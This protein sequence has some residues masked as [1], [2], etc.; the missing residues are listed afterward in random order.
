MQ[1][2][3]MEK[4]E[5]LNNILFREEQNYRS[6]ESDLLSGTMFRKIVSR[7][8]NDESY[9]K[10][11]IFKLSFMCLK[12]F[13]GSLNII[14]GRTEYEKNV[15]ND[16]QETIETIAKIE[17]VHRTEIHVFF[18]AMDIL[19]FVGCNKPIIMSYF[20]KNKDFQYYDRKN[21]SDSLYYICIRIVECLIENG[22][23]EKAANI[24]EHLCWASN[25][26]NDKMRHITILLNIMPII[27][28]RLPETTYRICKCNEHYFEESDSDESANFYWFFAYATFGN[29][30]NAEGM[31]YLRKCL[32]IRK[33]LLGEE[34]WYTALTECEIVIRTMESY[35][36]ESVRKYFLEF[37]DK[38]ENCRFNDMD[39]NYAYLTEGKV[40][41]LLLSND[42]DMESIEQ[43]EY[44]VNLY[45][46]ICN[47]EMPVSSPLISIRVER[48]IRGAMHLRNGNY[49]EAEKCFLE[50]Y[51]MDSQTD[52]SFAILSDTMILSNLLTVYY[53]QGDIDK[54]C[55][56][57]DELLSLIGS[58]EDCGLSEDNC[59]GIYIILASVYSLI[60][61]DDDELQGLYEILEDV[62]DEI[63]LDEYR[64]S[65]YNKEQATFVIVASCVLS[66]KGYLLDEKTKKVYSV[67]R[68]IENNI[69]SVNWEKRRFAALYSVLGLLAYNL[70]LTEVELYL[71]KSLEYI[72]DFG[73]PFGVKTLILC[74][75]AM[76]YY[77]IDIERT[78]NYLYDAYETLTTTWQQSVR[79][80]NDTRLMNSLAIAQ[81]QYMILYSVQRRVF[82]VE[83]SYEILLK[84]KAIASLAGRER[85]YITQS[86]FID[87]EILKQINNQQ[88][89]LACLEADSVCH[90]NEEQLQEESRKLRQLEQ[91]FASFIPDANFFREI[92]YEQILKKIPENSSV[93][94]YFVAYDREKEGKFDLINS[95]VKQIIDIFVLTKINGICEIHKYEVQDADDT[96]MNAL[97]FIEIFQNYADGTATISQINEI[98]HIRYCIYDSIIKPIEKWIV[99]TE[100]LYIAPSETLVNVPFGLLQDDNGERLQEKYRI[101]KIEC[102]RDFLFENN[103][104]TT[105]EKNLIMG[106]PQYDTV[107]I[108]EKIRNE[109]TDNT[110]SIKLLHNDISPL[111]FSGIEVERIGQQM[112]SECY[113]G[114]EATKD[115]LL[116][117]TGYRCIHLAT[118]GWVDYDSTSDTLYSSCLFFAGAKNWLVNG[119]QIPG[120]GNGIVTADEISRLNWTSV[121]LVVLSSCMSGM[122]DYSIDKE[123]NGM[124]SALSAAGVKYV[125]SSL[126]SQDD[127]ATAIMMEEFYKRYQK[128]KQNPDEALRNAQN[129]LKN[130]SLGEIR[131]KGWFDTTDKR[132]GTILDQYQ[133]M[134]DRVKPFRDE[135]YWG[136]FECYQCN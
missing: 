69:G 81:M 123:F 24:V 65:E 102:A 118:H 25:S 128:E 47:K 51:E 64:L 59:Y 76:Y 17:N 70:G 80:L 84:F 26:R 89:Y 44:L 36:E 18:D 16:I 109:D 112:F 113:V 22:H 2:K 32:E 136:G 9:Q 131:S 127:L 83:E 63:L 3:S 31:E 122:N 95:N 19:S 39:M 43:Y 57:L 48:N 90:V 120:L 75:A 33:K 77:N 106:D 108:S 68:K 87:P 21:I 27:V 82:N 101:V 60:A 92:S 35:R 91:K 13:E 40:L 29:E 99:P 7:N 133:N 74:L 97:N 110:R 134:N 111:P 6:E 38:I 71:N 52:V 1:E 12:V 96:I 28:D 23:V 126:W 117:A 79:Y 116:L 5:L 53:V 15:K 58:D 8:T 135:I 45:E 4:Y 107:T 41:Y 119:I 67:L 94:E 104:T 14:D 73:I 49:I 55:S 121:N 30:L 114:L 61:V 56:L 34:N 132:I 105:I 42:P 37:V 85:N 130:V 78:K 93:I 129:Y 66:E 115:V 124:I 62:C 100:T 125:I 46:T 50:A 98:E 103:K 88:D 20:P 86:T 11:L 72:N 54:T 10:H